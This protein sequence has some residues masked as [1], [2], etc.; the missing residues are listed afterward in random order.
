MDENLDNMETGGDLSDADF[1]KTVRMLA[2]RALF[3]DDPLVRKHAIFMIGIA[4]NPACIPTL[5]QALKDPE[6]GV[7]GQATQ[8]LAKMGEPAYSDLIG[9]LRDPDWKIR[10]RAAEALGMMG[11]EK[12]ANPLIGILSDSKDHVR[13]MAAKSL[14]LLRAP[15]ARASLQRCLSDENP[16]V[17]KM[18]SSALAKIGN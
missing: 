6:K 1:I 4:R 12:A 9:L 3:D 17:R 11:D 15:S 8:A 13:Y 7:R 18:A 2:A 14:G 16:Y 5:I 10:Y